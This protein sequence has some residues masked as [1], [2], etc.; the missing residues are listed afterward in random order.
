MFT[1]NNIFDALVTCYTLSV[2]EGWPDTQNQSAL[3]NPTISSQ[4]YYPL[5]LYFFPWYTPY[6]NTRT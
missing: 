4:H 1:F 5:N 3:N 2:Q 6:E